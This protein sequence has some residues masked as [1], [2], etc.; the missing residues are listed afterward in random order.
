M[1]KHTKKL[2]RYKVVTLL[3]F[4]EVNIKRYCHRRDHHWVPLN[5]ML[6]LIYYIT[7]V[8]GDR[9]FN[10]DNVP[11]QKFTLTT[12]KAYAYFK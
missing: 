10:W 8:K 11:I 1:L 9:Y 3:N 12:V 7:L 2:N 5:G 6:K 4:H